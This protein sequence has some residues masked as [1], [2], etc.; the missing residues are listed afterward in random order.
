MSN[1]WWAP[2][3]LSRPSSLSSLSP[4]STSS[5]SEVEDVEEDDA[6]EEPEEDEERLSSSLKASSRGEEEIRDLTGFRPKMKEKHFV[7]PS[8][9]LSLSSCSSSWNKPHTHSMG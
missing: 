3:R 1:L 9:S 7:L 5:S 2:S 4:S 8:D 6:E